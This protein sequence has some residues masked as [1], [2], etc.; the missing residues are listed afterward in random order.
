MRTIHSTGLKDKKMGI[1]EQIEMNRL[2]NSKLQNSS[3]VDLKLK[4]YDA[5]MPINFKVQNN[6]FKLM[7]YKY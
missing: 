5:C 1:L 7:K 3:I 2:E 4:Y 6:A